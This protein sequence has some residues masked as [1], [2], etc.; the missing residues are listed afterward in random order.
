MTNQA[1]LAALV[2]QWQAQRVAEFKAQAGQ[3][4]ADIFDSDSPSDV[5][6][7]RLSGA[8]SEPSDPGQAFVKKH[9]P[10]LWRN[11]EVA[12]QLAGPQMAPETA[13][14]ILNAIGDDTT[15]GE[16]RDAATA[17]EQAVEPMSAEARAK[18]LEQLGD[19]WP[20]APQRIGGDLSVMELREA[21]KREA[22]KQ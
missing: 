19:H 21:A 7:A 12:R 5:L 11:R 3:E 16:L 20:N 8:P 4:L 22:A 10:S 6:A 17:V 1:E 13:K 18:F 14:S 15:W 2:K 9:H